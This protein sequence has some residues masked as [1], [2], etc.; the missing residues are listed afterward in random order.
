MLAL[1]LLAFACGCNHFHRQAPETV[2][3]SVDRV[4]LRERV[5][6]VASRVVEVVNGEPLEVMEHDGRFYKVKTV[7]GQV[8]W[9]EDHAV[10]DGKTYDGF[11]QLAAEHKDD[12]AEA[13]ATLRDEL[14]MHVKPGRETE[15]FYLL[16]RNSKVELLERATVSKGPTPAYAPLA[17]LAEPKAAPSSKGGR[18]QAHAAGGAA[19]EP[20]PV[21][22]MEDWWLVRDSEGHTGWLLGSRLDVNVPTAIEV[23]GGEMRFAGAW[24]LTE[25]TDPEAD[26]PDHKVPEYVSAMAP[27]QSGLPYDFDEV[28]V[29]TWSVRNHRYETAFRLRSIEGYLP[30]RIT[31]ASTAHGSVPAFN[32][33]IASSEGV[34]TDSA[35]ISHPVAPR[36]LR[37]EL[38]ETRVERIGPDLAPIAAT[39]EGHRRAERRPRQPKRGSRK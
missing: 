16:T 19:E 7:Q 22:D 13:E 15:R 10:I 21:N 32:F 27:Y 34:T 25:V 11:R 37:Y 38:L 1:S 17:K 4:F 35:G 8:G 23:Y 26:T 24:R 5:A 31:S 36:T 33:K 30:V 20:A 39:D 3:V 28:R 2:Y 9:I 6:P 18:R 14:Y 29:Y 12:P